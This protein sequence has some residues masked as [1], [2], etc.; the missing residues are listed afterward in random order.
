MDWLVF[1]DDWGRYP[2]TTQHLI[3]N[4]PEED[5]VIWVDS[6]GMR[7][8]EFSGAD[9]KRVF[10]KLGAMFS[11]KNN[12]EA[13]DASSQ[14]GIYNHARD[15]F[16]RIS[17]KVL[18]WH[19]NSLVRKFNFSSLQK[20]VS[21][22][23]K[24]L[25]IEKPNLLFSNPVAYFYKD[26]ISANSVSYLRLDFYEDF[27]GCDPKLVRACE[28]Y[29]VRDCDHLFGTAQ[30]LL[31]EDAS[32][33]NKCTYLPQGVDIEHFSKASLES[34]INKT[35]GFIGSID[36][37]INFELVEEV[38]ELASDW[39]LEFIGVMSEFPDSLAK[40]NNIHVKSA[41]PYSDVPYVYNNW[42]AA[43]IP[44]KLNKV[45][46]RINP[47]K[48]REYAATGIPHHCTP[49]PEAKNVDLGTYISNDAHEIVAWLNNL[50]I[51]EHNQQR[52]ERRTKV[53]DQT[54]L[55]KAAQLR[56]VIN[57]TNT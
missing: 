8:P 32:L 10:E 7:T 9:F 46:E 35:L 31:Y 29:L 37:R 1:G 2:T 25:G 14:E 41:I 34:N 54:W 33:K 17:P 38:A 51:N 11:A 55:N 47:L 19:L 26:I 20:D 24:V 3:M 27:P 40:K 6:I 22:A 50:L 5:R 21:R 49:M 43:W 53:Q 13:E 4:L 56:D 39:N 16:I 36:N 12:A 42:T 28:P 52:E 23:M 44:Y 15:N 48:I 57:K 30:A 18:P 45:T